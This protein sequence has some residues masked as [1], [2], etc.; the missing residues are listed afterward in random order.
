MSKGKMR[1][2]EEKVLKNTNVIKELKTMYSS[3]NEEARSKAEST[4]NGVEK[5]HVRNLK[6]VAATDAAEIVIKMA[7]K[8]LKIP[9][10][11]LE[12]KRELPIA[13]HMTN[14][15]YLTT[16]DK[17]QADWILEDPT[18]FDL[19][20]KVDLAVFYK[21]NLIVCTEV[22][23]FCDITMFKRTAFEWSDI[24]SVYP[25]VAFA[26][27]QMESSLGGDYGLTKEFYLGSTNVHAILSRFNIKAEIVTLLPGSRNSKRELQDGSMDNLTLAKFHSAVNQYMRIL[28]QQ[29]KRKHGKLIFC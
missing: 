18:Q 7:A 2:Y 25:T 14:A 22:K 15:D 5:G 3:I 13:V 10:E 27:F 23:T 11:D 24:K 28:E 20:I 16:V 6:G 26:L 12:F 4:V 1:V 21:G 8:R 29:L 19:I 17:E 9:L